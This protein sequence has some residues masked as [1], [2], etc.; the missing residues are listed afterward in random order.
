MKH[1]SSERMRSQ[2]GAVLVLAAILLMAL[3]GF[4]AL[5]VDVGHI[6]VVKNELQNAADAGALAG[7]SHLYYRDDYPIPADLSNIGK[8][9]PGANAAAELAAKKN[10]SVKLAV[11]VTRSG[12]NGGDVQRGHWS[13]WERKFYPLDTLE[14]I[15]LSSATEEEL[16]HMDGQAGRPAYVNAVRVVAHRKDSPAPSFFSKIFDYSGFD[17]AQEA[18]AYLGYAGS[19]LPGEIDWP[20]TICEE[21]IL[22]DEGEYECGQVRLINSSD[23]DTLN[24]GAWTNYSVGCTS[25]FN[26]N[27]LSNI[28]NYSNSQINSDC[29]GSNEITIDGPMSVGGGQVSGSFRDMGKCAGFDSSVGPVRDQPWEITVPVIDCDGAPGERLPSYTQGNITGCKTVTGAVT[30]EVVLITNEFPESDQ[31]MDRKY[32]S[33]P[34]RMGNWIRDPTVS[35]EQNWR[36][37]VD[38]FD[39]QVNGASATSATDL[40]Y[41]QKTLYALPSCEKQLPTGGTGGIKTSIPAKYPVLVKGSINY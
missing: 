24:T 36:N 9:N 25:N 6:T 29:D 20:I 13:F 30:L 23:N 7:A 1:L 31:N 40:G 26:A 14:P 2:K 27:D 33:L 10:S 8:I 38:E 21:S 18:V 37:F 41:Y 35:G 34:P 17:V 22:N 15:N 4:A 16:D 32:D 12:D 11:E 5:A 39:L 28:F 3:L 19:F